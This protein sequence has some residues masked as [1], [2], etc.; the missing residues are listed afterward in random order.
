M[1]NVK[2]TKRRIDGIDSHYLTLLT[3]E[4]R[5]EKKWA[6]RNAFGET[7]QFFTNEFRPF[8]YDLKTGKND[9]IVFLGRD[10]DGKCSV[11]HAQGS[12]CSNA[13]MLHKVESL[14]DHVDNLVKVDDDTFIVT[15][16]GFAYLI[17]AISFDR[18]S[19]FF[20]HL[21]KR[22]DN[23]CIFTLKEQHGG[24]MQELTTHFYFGIVYNDGTILPKLYNRTNDTIVSATFREPNPNAKRKFDEIDTGPLF[25]I[26]H[27]QNMKDIQTVRT[28]MKQLELIAKAGNR[29]KDKE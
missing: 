10:E 13:P 26:L 17:D 20:Y 22:D 11:Y 14:G 6:I 12:L 18:K 3:Q 1:K 8:V 23:S 5:G 15:T 19:D 7:S 24:S 9:S 16:D 21:R 29:N 2:L 27:K 4:S 25:E 28:R